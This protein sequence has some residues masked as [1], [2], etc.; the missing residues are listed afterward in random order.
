MPARKCDLWVD[1]E[2]GM[3]VVVFDALGRYAT[4]LLWMWSLSVP[5]PEHVVNFGGVES[6]V[7]AKSHSRKTSESG[8]SDQAVLQPR[9]TTTYLQFPTI[10]LREK[11]RFLPFFYSYSRPLP[12]CGRVV[13]KQQVSSRES[14]QPPSNVCLSCHP[15][16]SIRFTFLVSCVP[17][18]KYV[19]KISSAFGTS[20]YLQ[21]IPGTSYPF[22]P[23]A[24]Y[25]S[26]VRRQSVT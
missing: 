5:N 20:T 25:P 13:S 9:T 14:E 3:V 23:I 6:Y 8:S 4:T 17:I 18:L 26:A 2:D 24:T 7:W 21:Y 19:S 1:W 10:V 22:V 12:Q 15:C 16:L 11:S